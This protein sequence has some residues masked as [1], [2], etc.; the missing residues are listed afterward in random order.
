MEYVKKY[1]ERL[2]KFNCINF[3]EKIEDYYNRVECI[4]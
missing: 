1:S 3:D 4:I 2:E